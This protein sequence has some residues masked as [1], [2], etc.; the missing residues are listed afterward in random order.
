LQ[1]IGGGLQSFLV[2]ERGKDAPPPEA[3]TLTA[4]EERVTPTP[5]GYQIESKVSVA[6]VRQSQWLGTIAARSEAVQIIGWKLDQVVMPR[7]LLATTPAGD[8]TALKLQLPLERLHGPAT[9]TLAWQLVPRAKVWQA[10]PG[11]RW[12]GMSSA[13]HR[14]FVANDPSHWLGYASAEASPWT[15]PDS[16]WKPIGLVAGER[17]MELADTTARDR[18]EFVTVPR[19]VTLLVGSLLGFLLFTQVQGAVR[20]GMLWLWVAA[21][22]VLYLVSLP[23]ATVFLWSLAPGLLVALVIQLIRKRLTQPRAI[24]VFQRTGTTMIP[25]LAP[26]GSSLVTSVSESPTILANPR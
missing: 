17:T 6:E 3:M 1:V 25:R 12:Q 15:Y 7:G 4:S 18:L 8:Q 24:P 11:L 5:E 14:W 23:T 26:G 16:I 10:V 21:L 19:Y 9:I 13:S 2:L 20:I 22:A